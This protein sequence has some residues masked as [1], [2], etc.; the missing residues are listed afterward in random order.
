MKANLIKLVIVLFAVLV[1]ILPGF[2]EMFMRNKAN[3]HTQNESIEAIKRNNYALAFNQSDL[4]VEMYLLLENRRTA[5]V[6]L[7][8]IIWLL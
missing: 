1:F 7:G 3:A 5:L 4:R 8:E 2:V 6:V